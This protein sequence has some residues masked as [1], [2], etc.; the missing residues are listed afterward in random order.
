TLAARGN[1]TAV[2]DPRPAVQRVLQLVLDRVAQGG[3]V[4]RSHANL[5]LLGLDPALAGLVA[6][7]AFDEAAHEV[8]VDL[9]EHVDALGGEAGLAGV[10]ETANVDALGRLVEIGVGTDDTGVGAAQL[11]RQALEP[12]TGRLITIPKLCPSVEGSG[13]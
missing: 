13:A 4:Q 8:V 1:P 7:D 11:Q 5:G 9:V 10:E 12:P 6:G 3:R 2:D